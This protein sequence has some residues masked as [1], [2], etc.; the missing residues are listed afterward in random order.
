MPIGALRRP[1]FRVRRKPASQPDGMLRV[2]YLTI[3]TIDVAPHQI[4]GA[5]AQASLAYDMNQLGGVID[6]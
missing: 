4:P 2:Y 6:F 1:R 3:R 5:Y